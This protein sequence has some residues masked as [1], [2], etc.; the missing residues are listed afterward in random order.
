MPRNVRS[1]R[2][3]VGF[4]KSL[5][6]Q[7]PEPAQKTCT[8]V[9]LTFASASFFTTSATAP[10]R[11]SPWMRNPLFLVLNLSPAALAALANVG[12][13]AGMRSN[14]DRRAPCGNAET[15]IRLTPALCRAAKMRTPARLIRH[16]RVI[17]VDSSDFVRHNSLHSPSFCCFP[18]HHISP[19]PCVSARDVQDCVGFVWVLFQRLDRLGCSRHQ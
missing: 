9:T 18:R 6:T 17:V 5:P 2:T 1:F 11:S 10:G 16:A 19:L 15:P 8:D 7:R 4:T 3:P 14:W 12:L 13:S